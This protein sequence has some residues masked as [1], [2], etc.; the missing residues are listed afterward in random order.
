MREI[1]ESQQTKTGDKRS[2]CCRYVNG[3]RS[4]FIIIVGLHL[5]WSW[6]RASGA[7]KEL[8]S[9]ARVLSTQSLADNGLWAASAMYDNLQLFKRLSVLLVLR[10]IFFRHR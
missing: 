6:E 10:P 1:G 3:L 8:W 7:R 9:L 5:V 4:G 2:F